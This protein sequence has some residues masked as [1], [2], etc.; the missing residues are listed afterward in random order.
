M[1]RRNKIRLNKKSIYTILTT[2][3][4][5]MAA[6]FIILGLAYYNSITAT[7]E[8]KFSSEL[9]VYSKAKD[10]KNKLLYCYGDNNVLY[11]DL[12]GKNC[13]VPYG[14]NITL[15]DYANC[16][17]TT[18]KQ[19]INPSFKQKFVYTVPALSIDNISICIAK[20]EIFI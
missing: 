11:N 17:R 18:L 9:D 14:Y 20:L 8:A 12:T 4:F 19:E 10:I 15:M 7:T 1:F 6:L 5:V 2:F 13:D 3:F 16:T